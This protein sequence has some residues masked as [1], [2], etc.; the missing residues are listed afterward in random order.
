MFLL[1]A[2]GVGSIIFALWI[3]NYLEKNNLMH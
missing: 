1:M 2:Y 3:F